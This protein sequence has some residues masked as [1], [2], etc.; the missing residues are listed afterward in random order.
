NVDH[1]NDKALA[2]RSVER[3][4][5]FFNDESQN[6]RERVARVFW[7]M[8]G[9]RLLELETFLMEFIESPSFETDPECLLHALNE[10]SVRLPNVICRAA[11]RV[12]EFIGIEGSQVAS[13]ASMA[14]HSI[15]TLVIRQYAQSTDNDL[16]RRCLNLI[17]RMERIGYFGIA[18][19][20]K[21][22]DR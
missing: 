3:L 18:D 4:R 22:L 20:M 17:D 5:L 6:V 10:S 15:S 13:G 16:R 14:A 1:D 11:E 19:E 12:L 9:E 2:N 8:S 21:K 7:N